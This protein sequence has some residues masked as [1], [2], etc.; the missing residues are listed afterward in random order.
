MMEGRGGGGEVRGVGVAVV[1][2]CSSDVC[3][4]LKKKKQTSVPTK[5]LNAHVAASS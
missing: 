2:A 3:L 1:G 4:C 5:V